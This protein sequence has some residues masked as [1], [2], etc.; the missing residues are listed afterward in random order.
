MWGN[1]PT[2]VDYEYDPDRAK[3]LLTQAGFPTGFETTLAYRNVIRPYQPD[4]PGIAQAIASY[5][6]AV[7]IQAVVTE[8]ESNE[9]LNKWQNGELDL[10]LLGWTLDYLHPDNFFTP[11][12]CGD[13]YLGYG[14]KDE[15][16]CDILASARAEPDFTAQ[17]AFY[18]WATQRVHA[19]LP[20][21]PL[22]H[23]NSLLLSRRSVHGLV[24]SPLAGEE[25]SPV[26]FGNLV[27]LPFSVK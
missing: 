17:E 8:Y 1:D 26:Y 15:A 16:L 27:F 24:P 2:I 22:V 23:W 3:S 10:F 11:L 9:F 21:Q 20:M 5:L 6:Q 4:P 19:T 14:P 12:L 13:F 18:R 7:G 25:F